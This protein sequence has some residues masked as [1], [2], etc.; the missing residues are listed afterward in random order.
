MAH[1]AKLNI[2]KP[3]LGF[4]GTSDAELIAR[5]NAVYDGLL[6][7]PAYPNPT[8]DL[9]KF[10]AGLDA[11]TTAVGAVIVDGGKAAIASRDKHRTDMII[12][13][14]LLGHYV[15]GACKNDMTAFVSS[16]FELA[17][18]VQRVPPQPVSTPMIVSVEQGA[19]GQ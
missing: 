11:F 13:S 10:K 19:S 12:M 4:A 7:N 9:A 17:L 5:L 8:V 15:E 3:A 16:G 18:P 2:L 6:N 14:R 1:K